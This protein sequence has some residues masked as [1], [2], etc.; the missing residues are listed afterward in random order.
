MEVDQILESVRAKHLDAF[1]NVLTK[2]RTENS[3]VCSEVLIE[4][5]EDNLSPVIRLDYGVETG[6]ELA[7]FVIASSAD[8]VLDFD[9]FEMNY[10]TK[11]GI[12]AT[13]QVAPFGW[14]L[15]AIGGDYDKEVLTEKLQEWINY[16]I[17]SE[18]D[19]VGVEEIQ[20]RAHSIEF[21][22]DE[23]TGDEYLLVDFGTA[24]VEA[25]HELMVTLIES[26]MEN[27]QVFC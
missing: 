19:A 6:D 8:S 20:G 13:V 25:F 17:W 7:P 24:D 3:G 11:D 5:E 16:W 18:N 1:T 26:G 27:I 21:T 15:C 9:G 4:N 2:A 14:D 22:E 10:E 23:E 12:T